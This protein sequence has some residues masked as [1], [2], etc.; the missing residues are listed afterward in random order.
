MPILLLLLYVVM[1]YFN[2]ENK[3][4]VETITFLMIAGS[5]SAVAIFA[6]SF[7]IS[8]FYTVSLPFIVVAAAQYKPIDDGIKII[9]LMCFFACLCGAFI[10]K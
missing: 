3:N 4:I 2:A 6:H 8:V 5:V 7:Y 1:L 10:N 9:N